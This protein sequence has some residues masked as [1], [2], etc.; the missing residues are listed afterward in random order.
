M[1]KFCTQVSFIKRKHMDD[2]SP[3][4][5]AWS[6]TRTRGQ[7]NHSKFLGPN[8][9]CGTTE[10]RIVKFCTQVDY[11]KSQLL[12]D[13]RG[14]VNNTGGN[15]R[16]LI[17]VTVQL[18]SPRLVVRKFVDNTHGVACSLC[19]SF[20]QCNSACTKLCRQR[21]KT[22]QLLKVL[23]RLI[24]LRQQQAKYFN[25]IERRAGLSAIAELLVAGKTGHY[26]FFYLFCIVS[27]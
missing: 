5:E 6:G 9:I 24:C 4:K 20:A 26:K 2:K 18:T 23:L 17:T 15:R 8:D 12:D 3:L 14:D 16:W 21:N 7:V 19:D 22:C 1:I 11:T 27:S 13:K 10:P 25:C